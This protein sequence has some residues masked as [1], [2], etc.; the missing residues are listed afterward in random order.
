[1]YLE[2]SGAQEKT[3]RDGQVEYTQIKELTYT[4]P[5]H[6]TELYK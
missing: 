1:M 5:W 3:K 2:L 6:V 4:S